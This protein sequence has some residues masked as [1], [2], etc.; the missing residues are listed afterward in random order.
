MRET[1]EVH[2][3]EVARDVGEAGPEDGRDRVSI[4][5]QEFSNPWAEDSCLSKLFKEIDCEGEQDGY[6]A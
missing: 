1:R 5:T 6:H 3:P 2:L 4:V